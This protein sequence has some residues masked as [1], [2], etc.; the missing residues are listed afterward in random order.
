MAVRFETRDPVA[1]LT[2]DRLEA[3]NAIDRET[4]AALAAAWIRFRVDAELWVAVLT[5]AGDKAFCAG[6]DLRGVGEFYR[7][8]T[9]AERLARAEREPGL[10]GIT[11]NLTLWKPVIAAVNGYCL[12]GGFELAL[13]CDVR[14]ASETASFGLPEVT[15][16]IMPGAGGTQ[17]LPRIAPLGA[18]LEL[19]M[20]GERISAAEAYRLGIVNRVVP[21]AELMAAALGLAE[22]ICANGPLAVRAAKQA[23]YRGLHLP[24]DEALGLEQLLAEPVRQSEDA[25]EGPRAFAEKRKPKFKG[26]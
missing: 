3:R 10:G 2:I 17:R 25:Q 18:A 11:R 5:A 15:W 8:L 9:S 12:A 16:G 19:I 20:T 14:I 13:A 26:R 1:I 21:A 4:D 24:L 22:R 7:S 6:A 23:V